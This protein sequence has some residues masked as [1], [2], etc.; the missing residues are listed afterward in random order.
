MSNLYT[1]FKKLLPKAPLLVGTVVSKQVGGCT[2]SL[3]TGGA[4]FA[5]GDAE[6]ADSV[7]VRDSVIEGIAPSL[8]VEIINV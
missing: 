8:T 1:I 7:F 2:V 6:V 4:V 3:P 5:R